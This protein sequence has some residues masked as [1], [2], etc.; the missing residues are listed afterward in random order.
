LNRPGKIIK[1]STIEDIPI[2]QPNEDIVDFHARLPVSLRNKL[3]RQADERYIKPNEILK[4]ALE[5]F[6]K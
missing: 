2:A 6:L 3:R 5:A 1:A 4:M